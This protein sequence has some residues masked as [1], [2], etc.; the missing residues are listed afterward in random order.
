[1]NLLIAVLLSLHCLKALDESFSTKNYVRKFLRVRNPKWMAKVSAI[2]ESKY[3]SSLSLDELIGNL[4][5]HEMIIEKDSELVKGKREKVNSLTLKAK[6]ES[7]NDKTSMSGSEYE[8]YPMVV[9]DFKNFF[10]RRGRFVSQPHN[11]KK[12]FQKYQDDKKERKCFTC[13]DPNHLIKECLKPP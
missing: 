3:L 4:K 1:M 7:S 8:E 9:R 12:S 2:K 11:E 6:K 10:R 5:V 13:G